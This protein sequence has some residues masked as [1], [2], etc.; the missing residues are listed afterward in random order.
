MEK[1][2]KIVVFAQLEL[3]VHPSVCQHRLYVVMVNS[4][5]KVPLSNRIAHL[6][7]TTTNKDFMT[8][9]VAK[10]AQL[11]VIVPSSA[12]Q[13]YLQNMNVMQVSCA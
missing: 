11:V 3:I 8:H 13:P 1:M 7:H 2:S 6:A 10:S 4:A 5:Q 9:A 12:K